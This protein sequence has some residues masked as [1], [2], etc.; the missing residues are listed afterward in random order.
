MFADKPLVPT[1][2]ILILAGVAPTHLRAQE[3][4]DADGH[5]TPGALAL[6]EAGRL[7]FTPDGQTRPLPPESIAFIRFPAVPAELFRVGFV[8]R[9]LLS[10]GQHIT[11]RFLSADGDKVSLQSAWAGRVDGPCSAGVAVRQRPGQVAVFEDDFADGLEGWDVSGEPVV[12][13]DP[14]TAA[15]TKAGQLLAFS[16]P[17]PVEA[18]RVG[19]NFRDRDAAG[20]R[21]SAELRFQGD[22][23]THTMRV[24]LAGPG[25]AYEVEPPGVPGD[26]RR[27]ARSAGL[28]RLEVRF[29]PDLLAVLCDDALL[30]S[31]PRHGPGGRLRQVAFR[32]T[33][34]AGPARGRVEF[35]EF[36]LTRAGDEPRRPPGD[37][38]Q[39]EIWLA[40]GDQLFGDALRIDRRA[41]E[42]Q[43][44]FGKR[45]FPWSEV[46]GCWF[47]GDRPPPA[48][49]AGARVR[50]WIDNGLEPEPDEIEGG[51]AALDDK[52][53]TLR[54][55]ALGELHVPRGRLRKLRPAP[56]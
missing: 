44:R 54:H 50:L 24:T 45:S 17:A 53:A 49:T 47:T 48:P 5:A 52:Q 34:E 9:I 6:D 51:L 46:R 33:E 14:P 18:G 30:W 16:P 55:A 25:D 23:D 8:R 32:C 43:G 28:H 41:V 2:L 7:R 38:A 21:W 15:L 22:G 19:V 4:V 37:P 29:A 27:V 20:A 40:S 26:G 1:A 35:A 39:E 12:D 56:P 10:D 42:I 11:G 31:N 13:R 3:A 36:A